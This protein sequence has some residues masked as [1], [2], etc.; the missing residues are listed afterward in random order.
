VYL[1]IYHVLEKGGFAVGHDNVVF[2]KL[3]FVGRE[4]GEA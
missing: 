1:T 2:N 4:V 3:L